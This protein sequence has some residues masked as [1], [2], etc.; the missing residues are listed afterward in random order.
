MK[1]SID[2]KNYIFRNIFNIILPSIIL[3]KLKFNLIKVNQV[4]GGL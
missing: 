1:N 2:L 3:K 4:S